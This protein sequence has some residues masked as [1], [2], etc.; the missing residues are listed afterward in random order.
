M[1]LSTNNEPSPRE[2]FD[3]LIAVSE[4]ILPYLQSYDPKTEYVPICIWYQEPTHERVRQLSEWISCL[5][6]L[7]REGVDVVPQSI[8]I[9]ELKKL[10]GFF[11]QRE[12]VIVAR[13][14]KKVTKDDIDFLKEALRIVPYSSW[15]QRQSLGLEKV[16]L[17]KNGNML[18]ES[19]MEKKGN[20]EDA[21]GENTPELE[22]EC[23]A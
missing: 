22:L 16:E 7:K 2:N 13:E 8:Q 18:K 14:D 10:L 5:A 11:K 6:P 21:S 23:K 15:L 3:E 9:G 19:S 20:K 1:D 4:T 12:R 17:M